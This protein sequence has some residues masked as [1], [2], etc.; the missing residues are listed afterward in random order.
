MGKKRRMMVNRKKFGRKF[1]A[2]PTL[3]NL[4]NKTNPTS[5]TPIVTSEES[6]IITSKGESQKVQE[7]VARP[8]KSTKAQAAKTTVTSEATPKKKTIRKRRA[9]TAKKKEG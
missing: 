8:K 5:E 9:T 6:A 1:A 7:P 4:K 3:K 2:H